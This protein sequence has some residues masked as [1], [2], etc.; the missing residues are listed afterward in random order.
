MTSNE[1]ARSPNQGTREH[2]LELAQL[3]ADGEENWTSPQISEA[4]G[5]NPS[6]VRRWR[7]EAGLPGPSANTV[8]QAEINRWVELYRD[9]QTVTEIA[10]TVGRHF[11]SVATHL[12]REGEI[13]PER[14]KKK[15]QIL[16]SEEDLK[17]VAEL[18]EGLTHEEVAKK[19]GVS[20]TTVKRRVRAYRNLQQ[21]ETSG[22]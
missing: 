7:R 19:L 12:A 9:G 20:L 6:T 8:T 15:V 21:D 2:V 17:R 14:K 13:S 18:A 1:G 3:H 4:T 5:V 10:S 22:E 16:T 11:Q